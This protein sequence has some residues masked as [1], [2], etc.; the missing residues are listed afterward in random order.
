M[1]QPVVLAGKKELMENPLL[2]WLIEKLGGFGVDR[3]GAD[4]AAV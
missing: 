1:E 4:L 3:G 2:R